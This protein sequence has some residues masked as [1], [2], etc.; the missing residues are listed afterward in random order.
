MARIISKQKNLNHTTTF[1]FENENSQTLFVVTGNPPLVT[2]PIRETTKE[3][4]RE[5]LEKIYLGKNIDNE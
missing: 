3:K 5:L 4:L 1:V 2:Q